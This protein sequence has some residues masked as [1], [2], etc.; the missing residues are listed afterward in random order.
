M[1]DSSF[2]EMAS[3]MS[4]KRQCDQA[5]SA[6]KLSFNTIIKQVKTVTIHHGLHALSGFS[7]KSDSTA[8]KDGAADPKRFSCYI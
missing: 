1:A 5:K 4:A 7:I 2:K 8:A 3:K 6:K